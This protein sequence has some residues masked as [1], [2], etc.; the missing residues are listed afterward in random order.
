LV[1][2]QGV[3]QIAI[4]AGEPSGDRLGAGLIRELK[5]ILPNARFEGIGGPKMADQGCK[6]LFH[7]DRIGVIGLDGLREKLWDILSIRR[8]LTALWQRQRPAVFIAVDVPDFNIALEYR[9]KQA[10]I[11]C[12]HYVSPTVWAWR[13]YRIHKIKRS[14]NHMLALF[15]FEA[16]F[17]RRHRVP[18]TCVGHPLADEISAPDPPAAREALNIGAGLIVALLP[19]SR[20]SEIKRLAPPMIE[21]ARILYSQYPEIQ[22]ILPF[23]TDSVRETFQQV[24]GPVEDMPVILL[25]GQSRLALEAADAAVLASGTASLEAALLCVPH[26]VVYRLSALSYWWVQRLRQVDHFAMPNHLLPEPLVPE[27]IQEHVTAD[28]I[29]E[30][31]NG[32]LQNPGGMQKI[33]QA[34]A[35]IHTAL[36]LDADKRAALAVVDLL[37]GQPK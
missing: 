25:Q 35:N 18:V 7:M 30:A 29:V 9:L 3:I 22:F 27:L 36:K 8:R 15:P 4:V 24:V 17:Y 21:A 14:I 1:I 33:K 28:N 2:D 10:G 31:V 5:T 16:E 11:P 19:G 34:F 12:V 23:A 20:R 37:K 26:V 13:S 32:Y 6:I